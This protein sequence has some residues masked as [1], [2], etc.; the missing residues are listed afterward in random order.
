MALD[1]T[2]L[3]KFDLS[4]FILEIY[5]KKYICMDIAHLVNNEN[6]S[7]KLQQRD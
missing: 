2:Q 7:T 3:I 4:T 1:S 6:E 5:F